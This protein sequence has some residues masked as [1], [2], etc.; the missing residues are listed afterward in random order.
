MLKT[1]SGQLQ[2]L[3][4]FYLFLLHSRY[5]ELGDEQTPPSLPTLVSNGHYWEILSVARVKNQPTVNKLSFV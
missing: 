3:A 4:N 2:G 5:E 1:G